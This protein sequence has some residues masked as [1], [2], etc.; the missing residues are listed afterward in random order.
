ME[1]YDAFELHA[2]QTTHDE[3][4]VANEAFSALT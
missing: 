1:A 4:T 3:C 2:R